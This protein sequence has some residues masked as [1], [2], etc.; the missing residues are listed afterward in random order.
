V[1]PF[2]YKPSSINQFTNL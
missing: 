1:N 2:G